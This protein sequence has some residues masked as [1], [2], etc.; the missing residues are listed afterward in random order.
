MTAP[1][2]T[3]A[4]SDN[5]TGNAISTLL[6]GSWIGVGDAL[7][8]Q[9]D[10]HI[11]KLLELRDDA[12]QSIEDPTSALLPG[13]VLCISLVV[14][15]AGARLFRIAAAFA[16]AAFSYY[17]VYTLGPCDSFVRCGPSRSSSGWVRLQTGVVLRWRRRDGLC[18]AP[19][20]LGVP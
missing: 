18:S 2:A 16:A 5:V 13:A 6:H 1:S 7:C 20:L 9:A 8:E 17:A 12:M 10:Q 11:A 3:D 4:S 19:R 14:L 15:V